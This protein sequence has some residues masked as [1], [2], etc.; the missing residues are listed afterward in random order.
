MGLPTS[1]APPPKSS[2]RPNSPFRPYPLPVPSVPWDAGQ[3][4]AGLEN[5]RLGRSVTAPK[6][7]CFACR[8]CPVGQ[9]HDGTLES[10]NDPVIPRQ[11]S[12]HVPSGA[13]PLLHPCLDLL[14]P[15]LGAG[16]VVGAATLLAVGAAE[17]DRADHIV[18]SHDRQRARAWEDVLVGLEL[19]FERRVLLHLRLELGTGLV[20]PH[21]G[22]ALLRT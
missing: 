10:G 13:S 16:F 17:G 4:T 12:E 18:A 14:Q 8:V 3:W 1:P 2:G 5:L 6:G 20:R 9:W 21:G 11:Y 19:G 22:H 15:C 7:F